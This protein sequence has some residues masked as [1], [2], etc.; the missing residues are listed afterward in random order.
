MPAAFTSTPSVQVSGFDDN[1]RLTR[2]DRLVCDSC[3]SGQCFACGFLQIPPRDGHP[4]R[5][6]SGSPCRAHRGLAPPSHPVSTTCTG[7]APVKALRAM[8]GARY[9]KTGAGPVP[10]PWLGSA[11][12]GA[13]RRVWLVVV[14]LQLLVPV[15]SRRP[16]ALNTWHQL[17]NPFGQNVTSHIGISARNQGR[18]LRLFV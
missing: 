9:K 4:C 12:A 7:T 1:R 11:Q 18:A 3:S 14:P 8:P 16:L 13:A 10:I 17:G 6:A 15:A 2:C 5:P